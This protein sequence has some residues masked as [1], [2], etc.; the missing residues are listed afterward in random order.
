MPKIILNGIIKE[1]KFYMDKAKTVS[2]KE[3][4]DRL[5]EKGTHFLGLILY[6]M[7]SFVLSGAGLFSVRVPLC[8]GLA[9]ACRGAELIAVCAGG[10][11]GCFLRLGFQESLACLIPLTGTVGMTLAV[12]KLG[13]RSKRTTVLS[14]SVFLFS[15]AASTVLMFSQTPSLNGLMLNLCSSFLCA[16]SVIFYS[17]TV[18]CINKRRSIY[19]LDSHSLICIMVSLC[20]LFLGCSEVSMLGF[21][22]ARL[23]GSLVIIAA[24]ALFSQAGGSIAGI[25]IGTC[26]AVSGTSVALS[27][28]YGICGLAAGIFSKYGQTVCAL[29]FSGIAGVAALIDGSAEGVSVFA[30]AAAASVIFACVPKKLLVKVRSEISLPKKRKIESEFSGAKER[31]LETSRAIGSVSKCVKSVSDGIEAM[32]PANDVIVCM[33]VRERVCADCKL[34]DSFCP[35]NGDFSAALEKLSQGEALSPEDFSVNFNMKCPSVPRLSD[36]FNRIY[37]GR[38]AVNALQASAARSREIACGQFDSMAELLKELSADVEADA[39]VLHGK[40]RTALRVLSDR[41]FDVKSVSCTQPLSGAMTLRCSVEEI[42]KGTSLTRLTAA[43][44]SELGTE[45]RPPEIKETADGKE[46]VFLRKEILNFRFG[47]ASAS[48]GNRKLCGDYFEC[49]RTESKAFIIMSD[50]MGTGGRAA[51]DSAMTVELFSRLIRAG[52]SP[53]TALKITN[54]AL[55]V[56]SDDESISTLDVAQIDLFS[57]ETV[58]LKAGAAPSFYTC[59][60]RVRTVEPPSTPL[61]ILSSVGFSR[62]NLRLRGGDMLIMVSDGILGSG[63]NWLRDEIKAARNPDAREFSELLLGTARRKCGEK[64][65]DMTVLTVIIDEK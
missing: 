19:M 22:P 9:A 29:V 3:K 49:F 32:A 24:A 48:C 13:F 10:I 25:S 30:E 20:T 17:G 52:I 60:G 54:T 59:A 53:E 35:E 1:R 47:A 7:S 2:E 45:L 14:A 28:C 4:T 63:S 31:I 12:E 56:K 37:S 36:A 15:F 46:L 23:F 26:V 6:F 43:L 51:I 39:C 33:R 57:G 44:S 8:I 21:R 62:Y 34:K 64:Y 50:G 11:T 41:D 27:L 40:E 61:G 42:P 58:I 65:D 18:G 38:N 5:V 16:A 55:S